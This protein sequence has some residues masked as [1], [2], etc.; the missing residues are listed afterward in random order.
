MSSASNVV[1]TMT[2][3]LCVESKVMTAQT[4]AVTMQ[5]LP[6]YTL[7]SGEGVDMKDDVFDRW[8]EQFRERARFAEWSVSDQLYCLTL[9]LHRTALDVY[10]AC[11]QRLMWRIL[12]K[13][14]VP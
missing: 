11:Y 5:Q 12:I 6:L 10:F 8:G 7:Y 1:E 14:S 3:L 9:H 2:E 13:P 4:K